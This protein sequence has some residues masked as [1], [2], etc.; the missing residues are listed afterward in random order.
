MHWNEVCIW[1]TNE[2]RQNPHPC[3][4]LPPLINPGAEGTWREHV[5]PVYHWDPNVDGMGRRGEGKAAPVSLHGGKAK[6]LKKAAP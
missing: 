2:T 5:I 6:H 3:C 1:L 4:Y